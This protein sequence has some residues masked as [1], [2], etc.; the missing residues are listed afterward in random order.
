MEK[1]LPKSWSYTSLNSIID[2]VIGGDWGKDPNELSENGYVNALCIRGGELKNWRNNK[3]KKATLRKIKVES[4]EKR[5][6]KEGDILLEISG[7]GPD[8]PVG[9]TVIIDKDV[10]SFEPSIP[11]I[12]TNFLR[13]VRINNYVNSFYI[14]YYLQYFYNTGEVEKYQGGSNNLRNL[15]FQ[16][17]ITIELPIAPIKEQKII[18]D[19]LDAI[20]KMSE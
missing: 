17:Y 8:Q 1:K 13:Q 10:L 12:T 19:K 9:R 18:A 20:N 4:L 2:F 7:G 5:Q 6:L 11:K 14:N 3:G 15:K 16:D